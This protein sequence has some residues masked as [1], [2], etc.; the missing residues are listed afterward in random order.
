MM[1]RRVLHLEI[2]GQRVQS[3]SRDHN[4]TEGLTGFR[5]G[6]FLDVHVSTFEIEPSDD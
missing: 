4:V 2:N 5:I 3:L 1:T 6:R